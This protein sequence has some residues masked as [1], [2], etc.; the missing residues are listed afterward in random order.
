MPDSQA[1][2]DITE[3]YKPTPEKPGIFSLES[4]KSAAFLSAG[5]SPNHTLAPQVAR[6][7]IFGYWELGF[8]DS[9]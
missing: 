9:K 2:I 3:V 4:K 8:T 6:E 1:N 5:F 7:R